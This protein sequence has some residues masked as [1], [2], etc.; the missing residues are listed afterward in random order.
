MEYISKLKLNYFFQAVV[1]FWIMALL[2]F[3]TASS[4]ITG[5]VAYTPRPVQSVYI[6]PT[7]NEPPYEA[8]KIDIFQFLVSFVIATAI[9]LAFLE[10]FKGKLLFEIFF[11]AAIIFGSQGPLGILFDKLEAFAISVGIVILRFKYP[12]IWTQNLAIIL[13]ISG[14]SA[15]LGMS[16]KP[17][18]AAVL[19]AILSIYDIIAVYKTRHM[20]KLFKGMAERGA[21][22]A[23]VVP[24]NLGIWLERFSTIRNENKNDF[25]FLGTG[26]LALPI[27]F[28]VSALR[29]GDV[30]FVLIILGASAGFLADHLYFI[31]QKEKKPIPALPFIAVFSIMGYCLAAVLSKGV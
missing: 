10:F 11:S 15:S 5:K 18:M 27:F 28:A 19:L 14:I 31:M 21:I 8:A 12:R 30:F 26:D 1:C 7:D 2:S 3:S 6:P 20:V 23:L 9:M 29:L 24:K 17:L 13:G 16:V 4:M 25:I 22:L